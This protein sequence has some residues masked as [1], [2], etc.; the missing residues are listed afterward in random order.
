MGIENVEQ[1]I[2]TRGTRP[3]LCLFPFSFSFKSKRL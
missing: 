2:T 1:G 3:N